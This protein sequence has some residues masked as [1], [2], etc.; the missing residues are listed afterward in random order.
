MKVDPQDLADLR[1][2]F[3]DMNRH[4]RFRGLWFLY[5]GEGRGWVWWLLR[6]AWSVALLAPFTWVPWPPEARMLRILAPGAG[7]AAGVGIMLLTWRLLRAAAEA[8][9]ASVQA[10][11][12]RRTK[13]RGAYWLV[14]AFFLPFL[15]V[16]NLATFPGPGSWWVFQGFLVCLLLA[17]MLMMELFVGFRR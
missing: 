13:A 12:W 2:E 14:A 10:Q 16:F 1:R 6:A 17:F 15:F 3:A 11:G 4:R 7:L 8:F 5:D 9:T